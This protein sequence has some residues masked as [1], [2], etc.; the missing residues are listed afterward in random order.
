[1][2]DLGFSGDTLTERPRSDNFGTPDEW[3]TRVRAD[4]IIAFFGYNESYAGEAGLAAVSEEIWKHSSIIHWSQKYNGE[5]APR[6]VLCSPIAFEDLKWP[7]LP[8]GNCRTRT[9]NCTRLKWQRSPARK[10][11]CSSIC[12]ITHGD[13]EA[14]VGIDDSLL[15]NLEGPET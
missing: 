9:W 7:H 11:C 8:D 2:R 6:L 3:L 4:V 10:L 15:R 1:V 13:D 12:F 5:S 14:L